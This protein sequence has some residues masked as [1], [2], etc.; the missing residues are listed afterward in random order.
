MT[1]KKKIII[2]VITAC[3]AVALIAFIIIWNMPVC[4]LKLQPDN[5]PI[6]VSVYSKESSSDMFFF[7]VARGV[8]TMIYL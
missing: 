2:S 8:M 5:I 6:T 3:V 4:E 7:A 1:K